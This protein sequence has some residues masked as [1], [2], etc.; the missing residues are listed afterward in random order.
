MAHPSHGSFRG[1]VFLFL[2]FSLKKSIVL[3]IFICLPVVSIVCVPFSV[4]F[5]IIV[6]AVKNEVITLWLMF[7]YSNL[8]APQ[9][10]RKQV[11]LTHSE[12]VR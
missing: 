5:I 11:S 3:S 7:L 2:Q 12:G 8:I 1:V 6:F 4:F 10:C 9:N